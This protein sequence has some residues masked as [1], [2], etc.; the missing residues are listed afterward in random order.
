LDI[1][2][3]VCAAHVSVNIG[4]YCIQSQK[5]LKPTITHGQLQCLKRRTY[6][7]DILKFM[8]RLCAR[9]YFT[10][11]LTDGSLMFFLVFCLTKEFIYCYKPKKI[12]MY[13]NSKNLL[14]YGRLRD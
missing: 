1:C 3:E 6:L 2:T 7:Q 12:P 10:L 8:L 4:S 13:N 9:A 5:H 14:P 11:L